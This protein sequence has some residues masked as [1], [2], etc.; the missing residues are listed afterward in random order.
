MQKYLLVIH[1]CFVLFFIIFVLHVAR[2]Q[3]KFHGVYFS[4]IKVIA[5]Y[6]F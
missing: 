1:I 5:T 6:N 4:D 2:L 3:N